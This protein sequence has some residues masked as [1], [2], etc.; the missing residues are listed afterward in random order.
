MSAE[1]EARP[2]DNGADEDPKKDGSPD[3][4]S[5]KKDEGR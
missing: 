2:V 3:R 1:P 5:G 4:D